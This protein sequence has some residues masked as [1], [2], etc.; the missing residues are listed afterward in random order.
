MPTPADNGIAFSLDLQRRGYR[1]IVQ[2]DAQPGQATGVTVYLGRADRPHADQVKVSA[3]T[4][5]AAIRRA[6]ELAGVRS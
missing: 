5:A 2:Q 6:A 3:S 1:V 4:F